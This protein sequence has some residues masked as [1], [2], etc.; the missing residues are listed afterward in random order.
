MGGMVAGAGCS[1]VGAVEDE[2]QTDGVDICDIVAGL[3]CVAVYR[4]SDSGPL[5]GDRMVPGD[6]SLSRG[7]G[8]AAGGKAE[9]V[10]GSVWFDGAL[11]A[12]ICADSGISQFADVLAP[13]G[14]RRAGW[15][16]TGVG[17][18]RLDS[19]RGGSGVVASL[20]QTESNRQ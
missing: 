5:G 9:E 8:I 13:D 14:C 6:G 17:Y 11:L 2:R 7:C 18:D 3:Y 20:G 1:F 12:A 4:R 19:S 10:L 15:G 16:H